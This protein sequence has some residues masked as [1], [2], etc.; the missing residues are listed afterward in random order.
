MSKGNMLM[1]QARGKLG[2]FV[3]SVVKGQQVQRAYNSKPSNPQTAAQLY[4]RALFVDAVKFYTRGRRNLF[5]FAFED[6]K[7]TE[8]DYNAFMRANAKRGVV[9][10]KAAFDMYYYPALGNWI[11]SKGTLPPIP[12]SL[13]TGA[14]TIVITMSKSVTTELTSVTT[15][16]QVAE[17][18]IDGVD[19]LEGDILT[20][21]TITG[22]DP[23]SEGIPSVNPKDTEFPTS[24]EI[25]QIMLTA[26][27][28]QPLSDFGIV[29][30]IQGTTNKS[31][32][33]RPEDYAPNNVIYGGT[34]IHSRNTSTGVRVSTQEI[35]NSD[36][37]NDVIEAA[38]AR[39]YVDEAVESWRTTQQ[40][41]VISETIMQGNI[42]QSIAA[43]FTGE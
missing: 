24:W 15:V 13:Q 42:A 21:V 35:V 16:G 22:G 37:T 33:L 2:G 39:T 8:S 38:R 7:R 28:T 9:I 29:A 32:L 6:K 17:M 26:N 19:F 4:Q 1:S 3:Y 20:F 43:D 23:T 12:A 34:I 30:T 11:M 25:K 31:L 14:D 40:A 27:S 10:S 18:L 5:P 36:T 41:P